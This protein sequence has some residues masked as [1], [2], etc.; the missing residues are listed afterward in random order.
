MP[1]AEFSNYVDDLAEEL[2]KEFDA[3]PDLVA[4]PM[5]GLE[6]FAVEVV[7]PLPEEAKNDFL[8]IVH[9]LYNRKGFTSDDVW[10]FFRSQSSRDES[11]GTDLRLV[12][13][14]KTEDVE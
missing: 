13:Q 7:G 5:D 2:W 6:D 3:N 8:L 1:G 14:K 11:Y 12:I 9:D 4:I 10:S